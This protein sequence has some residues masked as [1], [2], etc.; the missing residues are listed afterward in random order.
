MTLITIL[1]MLLALPFL[2]FFSQRLVKP[3]S[4]LADNM[5]ELAGKLRAGTPTDTVQVIGS[6]EIRTVAEAFNDFILARNHAAAALAAHAE[7]RARIMENLAQAKDAAEAANRAKSEFLANMSHELRTP[8]NGI[9]GMTDLA[10]ISDPNDE[11]REYLGVARNSADLLLTILNDILDLSKIEAGKL[12]VEHIAFNLPEVIRNVLQLMQPNLDNKELSSEISIPA[13]FPPQV[14]GDPLRIRQVL[15]NLIGNA[16]KFTPRGSI[17]IDLRLQHQE[18]DGYVAA[19]SV[20]DTGIGIPADRLEAIFQAFSQADNSTTR[21]FG[22]TGLGLTISTQLVE[23]MGG[24]ISVDS[25]Q[26][27]GSTFTFTLKLGRPE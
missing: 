3:L 17:H 13:D 19:I 11:I 2:W 16:I 4:T 15:L 6:S 10:L 9:I 24:Q 7:E 5:R 8:M 22:G 25:E 18:A 20:R 12:T 26:G 27:V 1:L 23:L 21:H 14:E